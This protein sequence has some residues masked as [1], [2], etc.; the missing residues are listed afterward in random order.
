MARPWL[1]AGLLLLLLL[2]FL[3]L[4]TALIAAAAAPATLLLSRRPVLGLYLLVAFLPLEGYLRLFG[5][6]DL[7]SHQVILLLTIAAWWLHRSRQQAQLADPAVILA[8]VPFLLALALSALLAGDPVLGAKGMVRWLEPL[9]AVLLA[10]EL[11]QDE[12]QRRVLLGICAAGAVA[13]AALGLLQVAFGDTNLAY[14]LLDRQAGTKNLLA[15]RYIRAHGTFHQANHYADYL[16]LA[17]SGVLYHLA[18][19]HRSALRLALALGLITVLLGL[20]VS[21]SRGAWLALLGAALIRALLGRRRRYVLAGLV[22]ILVA[23][24]AAPL[25]IQDENSA[26][27]LRMSSLQDLSRDATVLQRLRI[28]RAGVFLLRAFPLFGIGP[29]HYPGTISRMSFLGMPE[30][31]ILTHL[32]SAY[33]QLAVETGLVGGIALLA[34]LLAA[35][36]RIARALLRPL[37]PER[38]AMLT[39]LCFPISAY[40]IHSLVDVFLYRGLHILFGV[41]LGAA[42]GA[43][44]DRRPRHTASCSPPPGSGTHLPASPRSTDPSLLDEP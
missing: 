21:F 19:R 25:F 5:T 27:L 24:A 29:G 34:A 22:L 18:R 12:R 37:T 41:L 38:R 20:V 2:A 11:L 31:G 3:P 30:L 17:G 4:R 13:V 9:V 7:T 28:M 32:H 33:L 36:A 10:T 42:L 43:A 23:L 35:L 14:L 1:L 39:A 44:Q 26:F 15:S 8:M 6:F 40:L 16:L